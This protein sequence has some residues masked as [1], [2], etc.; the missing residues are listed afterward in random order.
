[1]SSQAFSV[2]KYLNHHHAAKPIPMV[3]SDTNGEKI[4]GES[5]KKK[6]LLKKKKNRIESSHL[7]N[8]CNKCDGKVNQSGE[9]SGK[10]AEQNIV[11][12]RWWETRRQW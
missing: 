2:P 4:A 7:Y 5:E 11:F 3:R 6:E 12:H 9:D 1:M 8:K 10:T